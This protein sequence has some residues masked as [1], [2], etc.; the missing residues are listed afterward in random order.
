MKKNIVCVIS[1]PTASGKT[2]TSLE[3][4]RSFGGDIVN[5]DSLLFYKELN[6]GTAKPDSREREQ[7]PHH[8]MD[9]RS[10]SDPLN[11]ADYSRMAERK[12]LDLHQQNKIVYLTGGSG[13]Y[14]QALLFG[15]FDSA[16]V[17][18]ATRER[19]EALYKEKGIEPFLATLKKEDPV[20]AAQYHENDH[21][22]IRRAVEHFWTQGTK[23]SEERA[24]MLRDREKNSRV[25]K[26]G[27]Q[28][29]HVYLDIPKE[30]HFEIVQTRTR[31]MIQ[32]GLVKEVEGLLNKG[33]TGAE[34]PLQSIGYKETL[35]HLQGLFSK[36]E[37]IEKI[38]I[39]TRQLAKAQRTWFKKVKK[40]QYNPLLNKETIL[41]DFDTFLG[42]EDF[43]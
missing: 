9:I 14:L 3:M 1:G 8:L 25:Q 5:F 33:F 32:D 34:K 27:W 28:L 22:R 35:Q 4:A 23:F 18:A 11:A 6:I 42:E 16:T 38:D 41:K 12:I 7:V 43:G 26:L 19:S 36:E 21:Y 30:T 10:A 17:D 20:C 24:K 37:L 13:F 29:F 39:S 40:N 2:K 15:M 31:A